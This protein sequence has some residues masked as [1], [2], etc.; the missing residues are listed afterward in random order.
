MSEVEQPK[1]ETEKPKKIIHDR[2]KLQ[3]HGYKLKLGQ[4]HRYTG[5]HQPQHKSK[6]KPSTR[7]K[8]RDLERLIT[9]EGMPQ[10]IVEA[11]KKD[12][13]ELKRQLR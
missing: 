12:I 10:E 8:I 3:K 6:R 13:D 1:K 2:E 9:K 5:K 11:K 7:K 4:F